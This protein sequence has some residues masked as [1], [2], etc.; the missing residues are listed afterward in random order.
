MCC[1]YQVLYAL[2]NT[3]PK[4]GAPFRPNDPNL[5]VGKYKLTK[6]ALLW[7]LVDVGHMLASMKL[8]LESSDRGRHNLL[9][10]LDF[11]YVLSP[12]S[13]PASL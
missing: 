8:A 12:P 13:L 11:Q 10:F 2:L 3:A 6:D 4:A 1:G 5:R 7:I 9:T